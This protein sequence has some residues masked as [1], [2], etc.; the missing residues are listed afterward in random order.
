MSTPQALKRKIDSVQDLQSI[1]KTMKALAAVSI[2]QYE[3]AVASLSEYNRTLEMGVQVMLINFPE[4]L[5]SLK[6]EAIHRLGVVVFGSDQGMCGRFN[7]QLTDFVLQALDQHPVATKDRRVIAVGARISDR[8]AEAGQPIEVSFSVPGSIGGI[9]PR[10]QEIVLQL[11]VWRREDPVD[12]ILVFHNSPIAGAGVAYSA[13]RQQLFPLD[14]PYLR[15]LQRRPWPSR[16]RPMVT[17]SRERLFSALFR[18]YFFV[19]LYRACAESLAAENASRLASMQIAEKNIAERLV[20]LQ[21]TFQQQRQEAITEELL[22]IVSGF[23]ALM[24][25]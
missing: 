12:Q 13:Q 20:E 2:R 21:T 1:V 7:E 10:I 15:N 16:C 11:E 14:L 17:M 8:L 22:D 6:T 4:R 23:E 5:A 25:E 18:Q 3:K 19:G 9:T 24:K